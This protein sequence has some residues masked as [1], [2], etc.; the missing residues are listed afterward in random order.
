MITVPSEVCGESHML[1]D[2]H[3]KLELIPSRRSCC[4][5]GGRSS[6]AQAGWWTPFRSVVRLGSA[7]DCFEVAPVILELPADEAGEALPL[8]TTLLPPSNHISVTCD[9]SRDLIAKRL[10]QLK[11][12]Q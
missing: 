5:G 2:E 11:S 10:R 4:A 7:A 8:Y 9:Q 6:G 1:I 3:V 12:E